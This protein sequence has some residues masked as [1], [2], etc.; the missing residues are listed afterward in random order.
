MTQG[1]HTSNTADEDEDGADDGDSEGLLPPP[2]SVEC[3]PKPW[4]VTAGAATAVMPMQM[5]SM[6]SAVR[7]RLAM[8]AEAAELSA[9]RSWPRQCAHQEPSPLPRV[10]GWAGG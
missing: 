5:P 2:I 4:F 10:L 6:D 8:S 3:D 1:T 9:S 7:S